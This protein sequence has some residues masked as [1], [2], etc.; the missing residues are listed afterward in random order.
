MTCIFVQS[1]PGWSLGTYALME[2][3]GI[4]ARLKN[5]HVRSIRDYS[6]DRP[7]DIYNGMFGGY[8]VTIADGSFNDAPFDY[9]ACVSVTHSKGIAAFPA[10]IQIEDYLVADGL[11]V[12]LWPTPKNSFIRNHPRGAFES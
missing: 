10:L 3:I 4:A 7:V 1:P 8:G 9:S 11:E 6:H 5:L 2:R 12:C